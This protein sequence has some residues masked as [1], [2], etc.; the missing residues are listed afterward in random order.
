MKTPILGQEAVVDNRLGR[1][2]GFKCN[3][4]GA[5]LTIVIRLYSLGY[6]RDYPADTVKLVTIRF[7][8]GTT[9]ADARAPETA[10]EISPNRAL[11]DL[12]DAPAVA[13]A[14]RL[15]ASAAV[16]RIRRTP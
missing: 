9:S 2:E 14:V 13:A 8:D 1:V 12:K 5:L 7:D 4:D 10:I 6:A 11:A 16:R 15:A 3:V